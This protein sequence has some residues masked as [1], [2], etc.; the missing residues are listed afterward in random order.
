[1]GNDGRLLVDCFNSIVKLNI[2]T[3]KLHP[4]HY[5]SLPGY[6]SD[7]FLKLSQVELDTLQDEQMLKDFISAIKGGICGDMGNRY[8]Y[9]N[10]Q[11]Q[12]H[13]RRQMAGHDQRSIYYID[14]NN[15]YGYAL[16]QK[17]PYKNFVYSN[18]TLDE[19]LNTDDD[20]DYGYWVIC[21]LEYTDESK[22]RTINFPLLPLKK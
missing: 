10:G 2:D 7:C 4:V 8:V 1:M 15:L 3:C 21:D 14:A 16:M 9:S 5:I 20:S 13:N 17:L 19:V 6:S 11:S 12:S 22:D 18:V